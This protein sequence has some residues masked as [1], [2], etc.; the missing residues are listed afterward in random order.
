M[1]IKENRNTL[2]SGE[3]RVS[4]VLMTAIRSYGVMVTVHWNNSLL[5]ILFHLQNI[6][7]LEES[8]EWRRSI[9]S[10]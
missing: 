1:L 9:F 3:G 2:R 6:N 10:L 5:Q 7:H 4:F 8:A